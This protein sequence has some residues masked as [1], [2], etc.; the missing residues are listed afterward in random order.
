MHIPPTRNVDV[1][2]PPAYIWL[3]VSLY[4]AAELH[5]LLLQD[6]LVDGPPEE[7]W[8]LCRMGT[9][10]RNRS[11]YNVMVYIQCRCTLASS[12]RMIPS[13]YSQV[14][15]LKLQFTWVIL[16]AYQTL[17][18]VLSRC[19]SRRP[20][21]CPH[22]CTCQ[23][24]SFLCWRSLV[25]PLESEGKNNN[26]NEYQQESLIRFFPMCLQETVTVVFP[27][28]SRCWIRW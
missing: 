4:L 23:R 22:R 5:H 12:Y 3:R 13:D 2:F 25:S 18:L 16:R 19:P 28:R 27:L 9:E 17:W 11:F 8:S 14:P 20:C 10:D 21:W 24:R 26:N 15:L 7:G 1:I 6:H